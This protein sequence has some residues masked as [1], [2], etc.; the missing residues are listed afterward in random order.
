VLQPDYVHEVTDDVDLVIVGGYFGTQR[1]A[2]LLSHFLLA[3]AVK[4]DTV[5]GVA[6][7]AGVHTHP[8]RPS[9]QIHDRVQSWQ[10]LFRP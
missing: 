7:Q 4:D 3:A 9:A 6:V 1:H 8:H 2:H 5:T 10:W